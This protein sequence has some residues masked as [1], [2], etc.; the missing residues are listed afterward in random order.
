VHL[1]HFSTFTLNRILERNGF[2]MVSWE[3]EKPSKSSSKLKNLVLNTGY[4]AIDAMKKISFGKAFPKPVLCALVQ[5]VGEPVTTPV[6][7]QPVREVAPVHAEV[8]QE[9]SERKSA[10]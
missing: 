10:G 1:N 6:I 9:I 8:P 3:S 7:T 5:K 2:E 4:A